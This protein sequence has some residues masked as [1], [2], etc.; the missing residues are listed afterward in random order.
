MSAASVVSALLAERGPVL[1]TGP[2]SP[3]GDSLGACLALQRV[4]AQHGVTATVGGSPSYRYRSLPGIDHVVDDD[5][6]GTDW[7][8]VVVLDGD[9]HRLTE[10]VKRAFEVAPARAIIDHHASTVDDGYTHFWVQPEAAST[11]EMLYQ[12]F[13][14]RGF[15]IDPPTAEL[16]YVGL[17]F[18]TGGFRYANTTPAVLRMAAELV[19]TGFDHVRSCAQVMHERRPEAL[20][21]AAAIYADATFTDGLAVGHVPLPLQHDVGMVPG[22]L[23]G[24][25][26]ALVHVQGVEVA[27]LFV[28]RSPTLVKLSIRSRGAVDVAAV[29]QSLAPTGGGHR[30]AAGVSIPPERVAEAIT[31][32]RGAV[33]AR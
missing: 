1:L 16:L 21:I 18:D 20:R 7:A 17:V 5:A 24:V 26:E 14:E 23:E 13:V 12:A 33:S 28:H 32:L 25:V 9:R 6:I 27:V 4:L 29:A 31:A 10:P 22:D 2:V 19:A 3:D 8:M 15:A 11:T 30:K